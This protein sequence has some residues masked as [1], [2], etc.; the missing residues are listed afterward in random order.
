VESSL[1]FIIWLRALLPLL[2]VAIAFYA[3]IIKPL[4]KHRHARRF[5]ETLCP[6]MRV[7]T[8]DG[9]AGVVVIVLQATVIIA[10]DDGT[11][12]EVLKQQLRGQ[13]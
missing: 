2:I 13:V 8:H 5:S 11:K 12:V 4:E 7:V 6:G 1:V 9:R 10:F 3:L